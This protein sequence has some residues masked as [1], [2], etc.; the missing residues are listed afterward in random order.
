MALLTWSDDHK[1]NVESIDEQHKIMIRMLNRLHDAMEAGQDVK[2]VNGILDD[3]IIFAEHHFAS[4]EVS[5]RQMD[6]PL[7]DDH[8]QEH[9]ELLNAIKNYRRMT[10]TH[11]PL[12]MATLENFLVSWTRRHMV[13]A[14]RKY[15]E[16]IAK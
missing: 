5:M 13:E 14:D 15:G 4:E 8:I 1:I 12:S 16:F 6:F 10:S 9:T 11:V 3:L 7:L 2:K